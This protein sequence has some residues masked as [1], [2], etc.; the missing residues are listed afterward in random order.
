MSIPVPDTDGIRREMKGVNRTSLC[1]QLVEKGVR[2]GSNFVLVQKQSVREIFTTDLFNYF[3][4]IMELMVSMYVL[5][6]DRKFQ[7]VGL[8]DGTRNK[9]NIIRVCVLGKRNKPDVETVREK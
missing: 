9:K 2:R 6:L 7:M 4:G 8:S 5:F 3:V 1:I